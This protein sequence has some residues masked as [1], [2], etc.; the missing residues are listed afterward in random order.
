MANINE[1]ILEVEKLS[2][3]LAR[4][5]KKYVKSHSY[6]LVYENKKLLNPH[7]SVLIVTIDERENHRLGML[8]EQ[9]FPESSVQMVSSIINRKGV[10]PRGQEQKT[11]ARG[12]EYVYFVFIGIGAFVSYS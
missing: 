10:S 6:G 2:P 5:I 9:V 12:T 3:E 1:T 4:Q 11:F 7:K 8:L